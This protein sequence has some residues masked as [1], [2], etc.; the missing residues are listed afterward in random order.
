M[1]FHGYFEL[2]FTTATIKDWKWLLKP[3]KYKEIITDSFAYLVADQSVLI[4]AFVIM[5]NHLHIIWQMQGDKQLS[6]EQ[7]RLL[8]FVSQQIK[9]DLIAHHPLV[10]ETFKTNIA[11]RQY[12][13]WKEKP[14][15]I[16]LFTDNVVKQKMDYLHNNPVQ[17]NWNLAKQAA[18]YRFSSYRYYEMGESE[19]TFSTNFWL[20]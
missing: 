11:D 12:H 19:W 10:L 16:A 8:K 18:D 7:Q 4:Y 20:A 1:A 15:S 5:P 13:F 3:D 17:E 14:L 9:F 2:Y 6:S